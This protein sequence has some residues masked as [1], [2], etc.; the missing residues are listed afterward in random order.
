MSA[1]APEC[2]A[3]GCGPGCP[4][5][6]KRVA[7]SSSV[8]PFHAKCWIDRADSLCA[9][10]TRDTIA[11]STDT[12]GGVQSVSLSLHDAKRLR[13]WLSAAIKEPE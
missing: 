5:F 8:T 12:E 4:V 13:D 10:V 9:I 2:A 11:V 1:H 6:K 3:I 7:E